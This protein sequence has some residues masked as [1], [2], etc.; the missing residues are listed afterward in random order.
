MLVADLE[1]LQTLCQ[2]THI[3]G[4]AYTY[5]NA[6]AAASN[7]AAVAN[8]VAVAQGD[9]VA[10]KTTT[11]VA[12]SSGKYATYNRASAS[13]SSV[14]KTGY[15]YSISVDYAYDFNVAPK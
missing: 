8:S 12:S 15:E 5:A 4:G 9:Y 2:L 7:G 14:A 10:V 11:S 6:D 13:A 1:Y 3:V